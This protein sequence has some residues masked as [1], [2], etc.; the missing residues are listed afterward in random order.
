MDYSFIIR[1]AKPLDAPN[2]YDIL[3]KAFREYA[4][5]SGIKKLEA[6]TETVEDIERAIKEKVVFIAIIDNVIV[7]TVR[8]D[9]SGNSAYISRF[10]VNS[11]YRNIGIGK[12][13]INLVDKYLISKKVKSVSLHTASRYGALV[14]FYYGRGFYVE[15]VT[16]DRGYPRAKMVKEYT[17][18][19]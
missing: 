18:T 16:Y 1:R 17:E 7:G 2:V 5:A 14:R 19:E 9:I 6:L 12:S 4:D 11:A 3:Q 13:L 8:V 15:S 10:A